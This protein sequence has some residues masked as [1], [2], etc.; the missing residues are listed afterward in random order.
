MY[1]VR[2]AEEALGGCGGV[3]LPFS[4]IVFVEPFLDRWKKSVSTYYLTKPNGPRD[5]ISVLSFDA[6]Y[7]HTM[8]QPR[9]TL[10]YAHLR[11]QLQPVSVNAKLS[12]DI[13]SGFK[14]M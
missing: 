9:E 14:K 6:V 7:S 10:N 13:V 2:F 11:P 5:L 4:G 12:I 8:A 3:D 1:A